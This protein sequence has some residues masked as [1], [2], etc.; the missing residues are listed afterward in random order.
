M[1]HFLAEKFDEIV[2][3]IKSHL[4][5]K[6][7]ELK[8]PDGNRGH[9]LLQ[10]A[11]IIL[12]NYEFQRKLLPTFSP[13]SP[14]WPI[15]FSLYCMKAKNNKISVSD[16]PNLIGIPSTT[17][18]RYLD[19]LETEN[20]IF[21]EQDNKDKRRHWIML[22]EKGSSLAEIALMKFRADAMLGCD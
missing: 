8:N 1:D 12:Q 15:I 17:S 18:M 7:A 16:V 22:T 10:S 3:T 20:I 2:L 14:L 5:E 19:I 6:M 13:F 21:K 9:A 4:I 11:E